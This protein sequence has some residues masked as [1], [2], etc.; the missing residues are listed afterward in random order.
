MLAEEERRQ[1]ADRV[2]RG[3]WH[4]ARKVAF[5]PWAHRACGNRYLSY[6]ARFPPRVTIHP[7]QVEGVLSLNEWPL[8]KELFRSQ[9]SLTSEE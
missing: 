2:R 9:G 6:H 8:I 4:N 5:L 1:I 3:R 7:E